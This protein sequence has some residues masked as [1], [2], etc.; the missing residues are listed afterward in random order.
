MNGERGKRSVITDV[1]SDGTT[2]G[3][4]TPFSPPPPA[5]FLKSEF[6][7]DEIWQLSFS[8]AFLTAVHLLSVN[9][10]VMVMRAENIISVDPF[11]RNEINP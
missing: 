3:R 8:V 1:G 4:T 7:R 9:L 5:A 11:M 6:Y 2:D 10:I